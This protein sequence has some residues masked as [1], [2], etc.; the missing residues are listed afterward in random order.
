MLSAGAASFTQAVPAL[1]VTGAVILAA[2]VSI[3]LTTLC[4]LPLA[5]IDRGWTRLLG[6]VVGIFIKR[7]A[8]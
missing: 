3:G 6:R 4:S 8:S 1:G 2:A 5:W 7:A